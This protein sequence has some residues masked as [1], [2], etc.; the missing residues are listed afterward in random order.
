MT[1][2]RLHQVL[3]L[4]LVKRIAADIA[5]T[6]TAIDVGY[7]HLGRKLDILVALVQSN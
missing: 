3:I 5:N 2:L 6:G 1:L 4:A 7:V